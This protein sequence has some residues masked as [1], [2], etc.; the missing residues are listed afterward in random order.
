[1][2]RPA[3][4][5]AKIF[6]GKNRQ[7]VDSRL[8]TGEGAW[9]WKTL[10]R[11]ASARSVRAAWRRPCG[12]RS[13]GSS[14]ASS[15]LNGSNL[16]R[17]VAFSPGPNLWKRPLAFSA[18]TL[19]RSGADVRNTAFD[20]KYKIERMT[21]AFNGRYRARTCD[22]QRVMRK[23]SQRKICGI[24]PALISH[25]NPVVPALYEEVLDPMYITCGLRR[26]DIYR[27]ARSGKLP[28]RREKDSAD[29]RAFAAGVARGVFRSIG[30]AG[31][32]RRVPGSRIRMA[33]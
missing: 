10:E 6:S 4:R 12:P 23:M 17:S 11:V 25:N 5:V 19:P 8:S 3:L 29:L 13:K 20:R 21:T 7:G 30:H 28:E 31:G 32:R 24:R 15:L 16:T 9:R 14:A 27:V 18:W 22:P 26:H 33:A 2:D 1:M